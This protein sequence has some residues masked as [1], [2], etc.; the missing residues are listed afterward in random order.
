MLSNEDKKFARAF[1]ELKERMDK[2]VYSVESAVRSGALEAELSALREAVKELPQVIENIRNLPQPKSA[3]YGGV[4]ESY[5]KG[6]TAYMKGCSHFIK[7]LE[8]GDSF[9]AFKG[10]AQIEAAGKAMD[11]IYRLMGG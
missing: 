1:F 7:A 10:S 4:K 3:R 11:V 8:T 2:T 6:M 9:E 5:E